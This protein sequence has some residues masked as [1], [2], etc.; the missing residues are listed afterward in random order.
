[1]IKHSILGKEGI[2]EVELT[3]IKAIRLKCLQCSN[4]SFKEIRLCTCADCSLFPYR[5]GKRPKKDN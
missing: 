1:M 3:P 5:F 2:E 4:W